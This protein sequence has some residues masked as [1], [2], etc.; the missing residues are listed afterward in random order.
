MILVAQATRVYEEIALRSNDRALRKNDI[1][2]IVPI[3]ISL[4]EWSTCNHAGFEN[5]T[6]DVNSRSV[7]DQGKILVEF[8]RCS[9]TRAFARYGMIIA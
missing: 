8:V 5:K 4:C 3:G 7:S 9:T 2:T 1:S 6:G